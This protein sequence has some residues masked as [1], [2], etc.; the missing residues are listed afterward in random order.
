[1]RSSRSHRRRAARPIATSCSRGWTS[2]TVW[3]SPATRSTSRRATG[4]TPTLRR[5]RGH[6]PAHRRRRI[7]PTR[8][9]PDLRRRVLAR[10]EERRSGTRWRRVLLDRIDRQHLRRG[11]HRQPAARHDHAGS[12]G[13]RARRT[14]RDR[15]AQRHRAGRRAGRRGVDRGQQPR[16]R[17]YP[18]RARPTARSYTDYVNDHPPESVARLTPGRELGW[19]YCNPDGGPANLP[20][21]RDVQTNA[22]GA[23]ARLR[24]AAAHRAEPRR[25]LGAAGHELR[26]RPLPE[27]YGTGALI[28]VHGSWNRTTAARARG[29]VLPLARRHAGRPADPG[30]RFPER[31]RLPLGSARW[32]RWSARTARC[33]S[34][35]TTPARSTGWPRPAAEHPARQS[36]TGRT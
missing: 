3:R 1:M 16:Q 6:R 2:H 5:R 36:P 35:T 10:A 26:R 11:P 31:R 9:S 23:E 19:P 12:A 32:P 30:R 29:V 13:R 28:G 15:R 27:P 34:P 25:A 14:V 17:R 33:T 8:K 20:L 24:G 7:C 18:T 4:W 21:I 22:D